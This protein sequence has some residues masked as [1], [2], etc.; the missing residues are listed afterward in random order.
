M[1]FLQQLINGLALGSVYALIAI[2]YTMVYGII[3]LINFAHG[4]IYMMGAFFGF[5]AATSFKLPFI[6]TLIIAMLGSA[7]LGII[8]EKIAYKPLRN[9]P[10]LSLL[11]T[12]IGMS[13]LLENGSRLDFIFGPD[14]RTYPSNL[15]PS[16]VINFG[17]LRLDSLHIIIILISIL[18][19]LVLQFVV[20]KT[21][22]G[23]AMR[24]TSFDKDAAALMGININNII[25]ITFA[26]GSALAGAAGVLVGILYSRIDP[27]M[28]IMPGLKA[29]IA[30]VLGGIGII[31]GA[32]LGGVIMGIAE[33]FTK[34]YISSKLSDAIAFAILILIL[35]IKPS[36]LLGK[37]PNVKV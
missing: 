21:K 30:A 14:Y 22:V 16:K 34:V 18:L 25:S 28:G 19:A 15:L 10:K 27:Y 26:I 17:S 31:P 1:E 35:L 33:T 11:I 36:G 20:Y 9:S 12:A 5:F 7:L 24:A 3:G 32:V 37:K 4:D 23:K 8:I 2:G 29:F 13:L 6:P